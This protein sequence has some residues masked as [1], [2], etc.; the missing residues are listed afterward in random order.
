MA[1]PYGV[2]SERPD[3]QDR[4]REVARGEAPGAR[5][6][7]SQSPPAQAGD[8]DRDPEEGRAVHVRPDDEHGQH[9]Q[10]P[11]P[12]PLGRL[13]EEDPQQ[14][15]E[16][17]VG[18]ALRARLG[19]EQAL[20]EGGPE[21]DGDRDRRRTAPHKQRR[22]EAEGDGEGDGARGAHGRVSAHAPELVEGEV[23]QPL[24]V[25]PRPPV[26]GDRERVDVRQ[27]VGGDLP[28]GG[29]RDPR[30]RVEDPPPR[31]RDG[32]EHERRGGEAPGELGA[33]GRHGVA[34]AGRRLR[35]RRRRSRPGRP[36]SGE[37]TAGSRT[38]RGS[39][40]CGAPLRRG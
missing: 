5:S 1:V 20:D 24:L 13:A 7:A 12:R 23:G 34:N 4:Y 40:P 35:R 9:E 18:E 11:R 28:A 14:E 10:R 25:D 3:G 8:A 16:E 37:V 2:T 27:A 19:E 6:G 38:A 30:V 17:R 33:A 39:A 31:R 21:R 36:I 29:E 22:E 15:H 26:A 32:G